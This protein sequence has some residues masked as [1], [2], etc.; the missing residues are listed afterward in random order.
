[1]AV[2]DTSSF[3]Y[4]ASAVLGF[5]IM[6][7]TG[8]LG[9]AIKFYT[10]GILALNIMIF[11][12][13]YGVFCSIVLSICGKRDY[14]QYSVARL[15]YTLLSFFLRLRI[16]V[17]R[18]EL[19]SKLP[20]VL[21]SNHQS[22]MDVYILGKVFPPKCVVTAK[23]S[24]KYV[25]FLGW[26]MSASGTFFLDRAN[27]KEA[28]TTLNKALT[29]LK[30]RQGGIFMFP[31]GTRSNSPTPTLLPFKKGA[32]HLA[33]QGQIPI[34]PLVVSNTSNIYSLKLQNFNTGTIKIKVLDPIPTS[35]LTKDDVPD[36]CLKTEELMRKAVVD[37]GMS[38]VAG[39]PKQKNKTAGNLPLSEEETI[40]ESTS[41]L[42]A[43]K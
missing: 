7:F 32:F 13:T 40:N 6:S 22:E 34:V 15:Y 4:I 1:M 24:L 14:S 42:E 38:E 12:A 21:I 26:F 28:L 10:K 8:R 36:L 25:P 37:L 19:L 39:E 5:M 16:E 2:C 29:D 31:E 17:D 20:A 23:K 27:R 35:G 41:L 33:V 9:K 43:Q 3:P 30:K 11:S 18:P